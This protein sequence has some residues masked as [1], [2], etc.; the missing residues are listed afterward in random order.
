MGLELQLVLA[1]GVLALRA[2]WLDAAITVGRTSG[3]LL[4]H[5]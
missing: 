5:P 3:A 2:G 1:C 4:L